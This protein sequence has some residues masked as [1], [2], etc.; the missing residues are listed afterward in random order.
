[1]LAFASALVSARRSLHAKSARQKTRWLFHWPRWRARN[2]KKK[3][4]RIT[5]RLEE[6]LSRKGKEPPRY[7]KRQPPFSHFLASALFGSTH[8]PLSFTLSS[9]LSRFRSSA[10]V[11]F[12]QSGWRDSRMVCRRDKL[13]NATGKKERHEWAGNFDARP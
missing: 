13:L 5:R 9:L 12:R 2:K 6:E 8:F 10:L 4:T 7:F 1:M 3:K 11:V